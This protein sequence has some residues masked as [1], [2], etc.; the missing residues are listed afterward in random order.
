MVHVDT[1]MSQIA[2]TSLSL[3]ELRSIVLI[4]LPNIKI[5]NYPKGVGTLEQL[6]TNV[7]VAVTQRL[8]LVPDP[9][10]QGRQ[11]GYLLNQQDVNRVQDIF[12]DL[13]IE[14]IIRPG[15]NDFK[16]PELPFYHITEYGQHVLAGNRPTP[17]D[18]DD[19]FKRLHAEIP[20]LDQNI[21]MYL[22]EALHT[23]RVGRLLSAAVM[24]GSASEKALLLLIA[25]YIEA[26][27]PSR[28]AKFE[29]DIQGKRIKGQFDKLRACI[30]SH[31]EPLLDADIREDLDTRLLG[32]FSLIREIRNDSGHPTGKKQDRIVV[33]THLHGFPGY[34]QK[35]YQI[36]TWLKT[37]PPGS[38]A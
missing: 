11:V 10:Q 22:D 35:V 21:V 9:N 19:Y 23:F 5:Q 6:C 4:E 17:Y 2:P 29:K 15:G 31:L 37:K 34:L 16:S 28:R 25:A 13:L 8:K 30:Q 20:T 14:G 18:P 12:W 1:K 32:T 33:Y 36:I 3:E 26:L 7:A 27:A 38:L 24:L